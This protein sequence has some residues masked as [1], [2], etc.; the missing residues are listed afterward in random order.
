MALKRKMD[1]DDE[2]VQAPVRA[3]QQK[4]IP[5]P[6]SEPDN[7]VAMTDASVYQLEPL[8]I[9]MQ[10]FH[11]RLPSDASYSSSTAGDSPRISPAYPS[12]DLYPADDNGFNSFDSPVSEASG[13]VGLLQPK[14]PSFTH[15]G[16]K[17]SQIPKLRVACSPGL[18]GQRTMWAH[19][20]QC[21]AIEM[22]HT[23]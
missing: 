14:N 3:K 12:F 9:P 2:T 6:N 4:L 5:F 11:T 8:L 22:V 7:D 17:C 10:P 18:N 1:F 13:S 23:D 15:H 21:G 16:Q 20:E 19:C